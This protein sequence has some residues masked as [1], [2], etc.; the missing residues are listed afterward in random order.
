MRVRCLQYLDEAGVWVNQA[1]V[2]EDFS[3]VALVGLT[4]KRKQH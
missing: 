3:T 1:Y 2:L 4:K